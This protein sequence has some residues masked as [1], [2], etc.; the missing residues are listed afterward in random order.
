MREPPWSRNRGVL[1]IAVLLTL[2]GCE[3]SETA[4]PDGEDILVVE[5]ILNAGKDEQALLLHHTLN[6]RLVA[7]EEG[8]HVQVR[9]GDGFEVDFRRAPL[10]ACAGDV[11]SYSA[12]KDSVDVRATCYLSP[13]GTG[14]W[15]VPGGRYELLIE[16]VDGKRLHGRTTV[17]GRYALLGLSPAAARPMGEVGRCVLPP[18]SALT[19]HWSVSAGA[20]SYMTH[21]T[22][23]GLREALRG[24]GIP[25]IPDVVELYGFSVSERDTTIT[26]P[27]GVGTT[28]RG[29]YDNALML[30]LRDGFP[31][32]SRVRLII[33]AMDLNYVN[34]I[35]GDNFYPSGPVRVSSIA[36]DGA[37]VFGSLVP[38]AIEVEVHRGGG[39][40]CLGGS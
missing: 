36:G 15:V 26:V 21:M 16:T 37:G 6:G 28:E 20:R 27:T 11:R 18:D 32:G 2:V 14:R 24:S 10:D 33:G 17:P 1:S 12:G 8:A 25:S 34:A 35:R 9:R 7:G 30:A 38:Y 3:L 40:G 39:A 5:S 4:I 31:A 13:P 22:V 19:L 29:K 23:R